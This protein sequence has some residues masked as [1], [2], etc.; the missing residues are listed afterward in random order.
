MKDIVI[1]FLSI[2][3]V[4]MI[5]LSITFYS[6]GERIKYVANYDINREHLLMQEINGYSYCPYC[7]EYIGTG[8]E[9]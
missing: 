2:L 4:F 6:R 1:V 7:G 9:G 8:S 3:S 5:L